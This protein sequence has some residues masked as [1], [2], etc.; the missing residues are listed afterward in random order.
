MARSYEQLRAH[1]CA[2]KEHDSRDVSD[3][4]CNSRN[5][6]RQA[7][8]FFGGG[9]VMLGAS[10]FFAKQGLFAWQITQNAGHC[11]YCL[12]AV[13]PIA[14]AV[15]FFRQNSI[16]ARFVIRAV[17][18][19]SYQ[20]IRMAPT[21]KCTLFDNRLTHAHTHT[22]THTQTVSSPRCTRCGGNTCIRGPITILHYC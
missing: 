6:K 10:V 13:S 16:G 12:T 4:R 7:S 14:P 3:G 1:P 17:Q 9:A 19:N 5:L 15:S 20:K 2:H 22:H 8:D 18:K 21:F 11:F